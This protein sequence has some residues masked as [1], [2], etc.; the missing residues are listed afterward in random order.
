VTARVP[1]PLDPLRAR[2]AAG[3]PFRGDLARAFHRLVAD[4]DPLATDETL[5]PLEG[6]KGTHIH[7]SLVGWSSV[8]RG[9]RVLDVGCGAGGAAF[10]AAEAV[11]E[12]GIV[13]GLDPSPRSLEVARLRAPEDLP[14]AFVRGDADDL[15]A[16]PDRGM[17]CI[18]ASLVL[19]RID[20]LAP[21]AA[22]AFRVLRPGGRLV[23]SVMD[24]DSLRPAD[25]AFH[26]AALAVLARHAPGAFSGRASRQGIPRDRPDAAAFAA[27]GLASL[28]EREGQLVAPLPTPE[29]AW[30]LYSRSVLAQMMGEDGQAELRAVLA[31]RVPHTLYLPVRFIRTRRPG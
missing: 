13:V 30:A 21:F 2:L 12:Q 23:A 31:A 10:V 24:F 26:A 22:E 25:A 18:I 14:M 15:S 6:N 27:A 9:E 3:E 16:V 1:S 5:A 4:A 17:D 29:A 11:G 19:D 7:R 28:E 8:T 20:D